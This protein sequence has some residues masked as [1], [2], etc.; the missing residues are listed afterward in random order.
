M[1]QPFIYGGETGRTYADMTRAREIAKALMQGTEAPK[2]VGEGLNAIGSA[3]LA[4]A[5]TKRADRLRDQVASQI[6][7][8][9]PLFP[10]LYGLP[11]YRNGTNFHPGGLAVV[12]EEGPEI[13][14]LPRGASVIPNPM[15][16]AFRPGV[17][18]ANAYRG[19]ATPDM[20]QIMLAQGAQDPDPTA[21]GQFFVDPE[22]TVPPNLMERYK[23]LPLDMQRSIMEQI[24][25][26]APPEEMIPPKRS[27]AL[28]SPAAL[29]QAGAMPPEA[30]G[31]PSRFIDEQAVQVA[32]ASGKRPVFDNK[33]TEGQSK[34]VGFFRRG[35]AA[36][37][38]LAKYEDALL[39]I[40][41]TA[42]EK[43]PLGLGRFLQD[44]EFQQARRAAN[45]V[46]AVM[47]RKD[48]GAQ[49]TNEEFALYAPMYIPMPGDKPEVLAAKRAAREQFFTGLQD[50]MGT[51]APIAQFT[52]EELMNMNDDDFLKS[53]GI[54]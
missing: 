17:D 35:L 36:N 18:A 30:M 40:S 10:K 46:L 50:G 11:A 32:D 7:A 3:L 6:P 21:G 22:N 52:R 19:P 44:E 49:V 8:D 25:Q 53:L 48:T 4:K 29:M 15:T 43:V 24:M 38:E 42:L 1:T 26:G 41:D 47:L 5:Q 31:Q 9:H 20:A 37:Q 2:N 23:A 45:E 13:V 12:G 33:L 16:M 28:A 54:E 51:A 27:G 34:D 39:Q 14:Q